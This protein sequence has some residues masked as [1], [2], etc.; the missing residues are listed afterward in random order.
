MRLVRPEEIL[1][2]VYESFRG[3]IPFV[4]IGCALLEEDGQ[5]LRAFW[6]RAE[7]EGLQCPMTSATPRT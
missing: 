5:V 7:Y 3:L 6:A 2:T 1:T 4:R